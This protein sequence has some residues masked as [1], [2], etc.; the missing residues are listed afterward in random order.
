MPI[1]PFY[2]NKADLELK[3]LV[4]YLNKFISE[5]DVRELNSKTMRLADYSKF[6]NP[7]DLIKTLYTV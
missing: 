1:V 2:D 5:P 4:D 7:S 3:S 6:R